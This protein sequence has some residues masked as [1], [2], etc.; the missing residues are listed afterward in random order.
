MKM[1][2]RLIL[3]FVLVVVV[4]IASVLVIA[5][6]GAVTEVRMFMRGSMMGLDDLAL[7]LEYYYQETGSWQGAD[8]LL[9]ASRGGHG[10]GQ[11]M[12]AERPAAAPG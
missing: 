1:R 12:M 4:T 10:M 9:A 5:R 8:V 7:Q 3:S 6:Q 11:G 2:L